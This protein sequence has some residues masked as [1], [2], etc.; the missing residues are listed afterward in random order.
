MKQMISVF[1]KNHFDR[2]SMYLTPMAAASTVTTKL[3]LDESPL[4][5]IEKLLMSIIKA[6]ATSNEV[7]Q[8]HGHTGTEL[9]LS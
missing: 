3:K 5:L 9:L 2:E 8:V 6:C 1:V 4:E 7:Y